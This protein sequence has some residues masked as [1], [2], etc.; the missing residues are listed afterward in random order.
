MSLS[1]W[2]GASVPLQGTGHRNKKEPFLDFLRVWGLLPQ[3][4]AAF[5]D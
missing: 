5:P 4:G 2:A 1:H 3:V